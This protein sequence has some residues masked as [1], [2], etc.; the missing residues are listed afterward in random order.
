LLHNDEIAAKYK[1]AI[2]F[3]LIPNIFNN[4]MKNRLGGLTMKMSV[5][6][7]VV[8]LIAT[9][10][11]AWSSVTLAADY[12]AL[13]NDQL[14]DLRATASSMTNDERALLRDE[15]RSRVSA[16]SPEERSAF[17]SLNS[18][19][20]RDGSGED[21]RRYGSG[22]SQGQGQMVRQRL[23]DGSGGGSRKGQGRR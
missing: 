22:N 5:K 1:R 2:I 9:L 8:P 6:M 14:F 15:V 17:R 12:T 19:R 21:G 16:M 23:R 3:S 13:S 11:G 4:S 10:A 20:Q 18:T 7:V